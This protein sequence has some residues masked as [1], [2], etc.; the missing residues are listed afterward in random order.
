M[1]SFLNQY[2]KNHVFSQN[3]EEGILLECLERMYFDVNKGHA[4]EIGGNDGRF[5]SNTAYLLQNRGWTGLFVEESYDLHLQSKKNW[6]AFGLNVRSQC[7]RVDGKNINAFVDDRCDVL[8]L[9]TDGSDY[10]IFDGLKA[11]PKIVIAEIDSSLNPDFASFNGDG[12]ANYFAMALLGVTKGYFLLCHTGNM[13]FVDKQYK[14][15]FPEIVGDPLVDID[16]YF[17]R[18]WL[19]EE[20][21]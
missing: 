21:A 10:L 16:L 4:V 3:G 20:A 17:N 7:S 15:L 14:D 8:S 19:K 2:A 6:E 1:L 18:A 9:D 13:V 12:A 5:C 11:K